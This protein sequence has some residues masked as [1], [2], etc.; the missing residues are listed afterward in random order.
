MVN[1]KKVSP[2][3]HIRFVISTLIL[4]FSLVVTAYAII[5]QH[6]SFWKSVPGYV[7][8]IIFIVDLSILGIVEGLQ[9]ALVELKRQHP[10]AYRESHPQAYRLGQVAAH[11]DNVERYRN[12][13]GV[14]INNIN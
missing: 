10:D 14:L 3:D 5:M 8:L 1:L 12:H 9:I 4:L 6:T 13:E 11:G 7:A 2:W